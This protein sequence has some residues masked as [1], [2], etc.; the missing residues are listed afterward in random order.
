MILTVVSVRLTYDDVHQPA[1]LR[2]LDGLPFIKI[3][4]LKLPFLLI[5]LGEILEL[6]LQLTYRV[7]R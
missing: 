7:E 6:V 5:E 1:A 3:L 4:L 2:R